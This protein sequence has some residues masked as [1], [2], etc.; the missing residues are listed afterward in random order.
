MEEQTSDL[1]KSEEYLKEKI[2]E[3][4]IFCDAAGD[5]EL[6]MEELRVE[7]KKITDSDRNIGKRI[8]TA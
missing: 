6:R 8:P 2:K 1:K 3:L 5:R 7:I 4:E